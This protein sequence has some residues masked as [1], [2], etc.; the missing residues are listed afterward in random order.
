MEDQPLVLLFYSLWL[1]RH[2]QRQTHMH[3]HM[4]VI[5]VQIGLTLVHIPESTPQLC[6]S[7][8]NRCVT[9]QGSATKGT[10]PTQMHLTP[11]FWVFHPGQ[12]GQPK[13]EAAWSARRE[14]FT[15]KERIH[16]TSSRVEASRIKWLQPNQP[17]KSEEESKPKTFGPLDFVC[18]A[19][20]YSI[21]IFLIWV[22]L[23][24]LPDL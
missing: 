17:Q 21:F 9:T 10:T 14:I 13:T 1:Y 6:Q 19:L 12:F 16:V 22:I 3:V 18:L 4:P 11:G 5:I 2:P 15:N 24:N 8:P 23:N 20:Q 7:L